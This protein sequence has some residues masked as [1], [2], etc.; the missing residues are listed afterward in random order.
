MAADGALFGLPKR[1]RGRHERAMEATIRLWRR[2]GHS[3]DPAASSAL[4]E[5]AG[6]VDLAIAKGEQWHISN[7]LTTEA[8]L[9]RE[10]GPTTG[11]DQFDAF[12][13]SL[14]DDRDPVAGAPQIRDSP[15]ARPPDLR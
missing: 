14:T 8:Q 15:P 1:T 13:A 12:M 9:R 7:C 11:V 5:Q 10:Y 6:A 2:D 4:R 3:L